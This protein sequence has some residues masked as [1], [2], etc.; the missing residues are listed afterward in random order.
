MG[1]STSPNTL[2]PQVNI[3]GGA[4]DTVSMAL[5]G[6]CTS[7]ATQGS[8]IRFTNNNATSGVRNKSIRVNNSGD[9][10]ILNSAYNAPLLTIDEAGGVTAG[11]S[12]AGSA[13]LI[14]LNTLG[15]L[16][17]FTLT[18]QCQNSSASDNSVA[19]FGLVTGVANMN[20]LFQLNNGVASAGS[21]II[22][23]GSA[24]TGGL[25]IT[26]LAGGL[27]LNPNNSAVLVAGTIKS[28]T[29]GANGGIG[30]ATGAGGTVTQA[31]SRTTGVTLNTPTGDITMFSAAGS[32][33]PAAF[34]VTNSAVAGSDIIALN[35]RSGA[36]NVY[37]LVVTTVAAGSFTV[38]FWTTGGTAT[39][40]PVIQF[41]VIKG[42]TN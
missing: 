10:E 27:N 25:A 36:S 34:T 28:N 40:A 35:I 11:N 15:N 39:D 6:N 22:Q 38:T 20:A 19:K 16:P 31:T 5:I 37:N 29:T 30:Y 32:A 41:A 8:Q 23:T 17:A 1:W 33:T 3:T 7:D 14:G 2:V 26:T 13:G 9:M 42:V 24:V 12:T 18:T 4:N 21:A